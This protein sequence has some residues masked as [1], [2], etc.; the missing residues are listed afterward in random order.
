MARNC[1]EEASRVCPDSPYAALAGIRMLNMP[2]VNGPVHPDIGGS[3]EQ[4]V[5]PPDVIRESRADLHRIQESRRMLNLAENFLSAGDFDHAYR[6][7]QEAHAICPAC[8]YGQQALERMLRLE[9]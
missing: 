3:E 9:A 1:Y 4:S 2:A 8:K 6:C 5:P 7:Y